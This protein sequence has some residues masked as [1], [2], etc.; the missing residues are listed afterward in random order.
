MSVK[1]KVNVESRGRV[2]LLNILQ[3]FRFEAAK[4]LYEQAPNQSQISAKPLNEN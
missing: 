4:F 2:L 3:A 1:F